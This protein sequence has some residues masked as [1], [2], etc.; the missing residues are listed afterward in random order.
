MMP[1]GLW[2]PELGTALI[3]DPEVRLPPMSDSRPRACTRA[4]RSTRRLGNRVAMLA[5][6]RD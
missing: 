1:L 2:N 5:H 4:G 3:L 6:C